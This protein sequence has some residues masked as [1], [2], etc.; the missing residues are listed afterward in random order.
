MNLPNAP[1]TRTSLHPEGMGTDLAALE[2]VVLITT[3]QI[4]ALTALA[5]VPGVAEASI[6]ATGIAAVSGGMATVVGVAAPVVHAYLR[7]SFAK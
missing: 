5:A 6:G 2:M 4:T 3:A 7:K 1:E